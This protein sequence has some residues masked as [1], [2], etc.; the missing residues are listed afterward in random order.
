MTVDGMQK[1]KRPVVN[2]GWKKAYVEGF[3]RVVY[4]HY[5]PHRQLLYTTCSKLDPLSHPPKKDLK[6]H[7]MVPEVGCSRI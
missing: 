2:E 3:I 6:D 5:K 7:N 4:G 1:W